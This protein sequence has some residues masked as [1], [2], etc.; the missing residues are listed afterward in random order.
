MSLPLVLGCV[1]VVASAIVA[2][3]P[4]RAQM[5]PGTALL[6]GAPLLLVWIGVE[7]GALWTLVGVFAFLSTFRRPLTYFARRALGLPASLPP[8]LVR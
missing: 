7:H 1:W 2:M 3:L 6:V 4:M 8:E 5:V